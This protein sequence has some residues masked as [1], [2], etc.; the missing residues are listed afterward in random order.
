MHEKVKSGFGEL[1]EVA[2]DFIVTVVIFSTLLT[3]FSVELASTAKSSWE[4][5]TTVAGEN[6]EYR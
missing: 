6:S 4:F 3:L 5:T 2:D 1:L